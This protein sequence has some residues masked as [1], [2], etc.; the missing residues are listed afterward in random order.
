M[1]LFNQDKIILDLCGGTGAWSKPYEEAG[2]DVRVITLP[3]DIRLFER[4][5]HRD[6]YGILA[7]PPCSHFASVGIRWWNDKDNDGRTLEDISVMDAC[8]RIILVC[9][10]VFWCLENPKG[11]MGRFLGDPV[12]TFHPCEFGDPYRKLTCLWGIFKRP[13]T[14]PSV[15]PIHAKSDESAIDRYIQDIKGLT[16]TV[17]N[18][19]GLR[20]ITPAG[21]AKAFFEANP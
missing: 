4:I 18:R 14:G 12:M 7:A 3:Q 2:Y 13:V 1:K 6:V 15:K 19:A 11:R 17:K 8:M 16:L 5:K 9:K 21:F 20:S 10:P